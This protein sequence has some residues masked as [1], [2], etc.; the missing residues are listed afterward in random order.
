[1]EV[2]HLVKSGVRVTGFK[3]GR[4]V[5]VEE[6][7][8]AFVSKGLI[9]GQ[10]VAVFQEEKLVGLAI[11]NRFS[12]HFGQLIKSVAFHPSLATPQL[13]TQVEEAEFVPPYIRQKLG[14]AWLRRQRF[15]AFSQGRLCYGGE[16]DLPG[17]IIDL[18]QN[19]VIYQINLAGVDR[20]R[21]VVHQWLNERF[22]DRAIFNLENP[23]YRQAE[24]LSSYREHP[25]EG[26]IKFLENGL[27]Y[28]IDAAVMQKIGHYFDHARNRQR[29]A[30]VV[31][32]FRATQNLAYGLDLFCYGGSWGLN[33]LKAGVEQ[34]DFVDQGNFGATL[35]R[36]LALNGLAGRGTFWRD[37]VFNFLAAPPKKQYQ[38]VVCDPPAFAKSG[39]KSPQ[40]GY[41]KLYRL[42][43]PHLAS[44][45][46]VAVA[47]C[48]QGIGL[49]E[50]DQ[51]IQQVWPQKR[52]T[53]LDLGGHNYDHPITSL[54][55]KSYYL[56][57]LLYLVEN[58]EN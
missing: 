5:A 17:L 48:T 16:D 58:L 52:I 45:A 36:H 42:L 14:Q 9:P 7:D 56:K 34:V 11:I 39:Q 54:R 19:C 33:L 22:P 24:G 50:L 12:K 15:G 25:V 6:K 57:Y 37:D 26:E 23:V 10:W 13:A 18:Y 31:R 40:V 4:V 32:Q 49:S 46:L 2:L 53:L 44:P 38:V 8:F 3:S 20:F 30:E 35:A 27:E 1:M 47:S 51:I 21:A 43:G 41:T 28:V 55:S 29:C